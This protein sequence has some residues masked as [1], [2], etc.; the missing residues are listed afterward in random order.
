[1]KKLR[2]AL[3]VL[4][5]IALVGIAGL[6]AVSTRFPIRYMDIITANAGELEPSLVLAVIMAESS[7]NENALSRVGAQGLMQLMPA[8]AADIARRMGNTAFV[9]DD[10]WDSET[11]ITMGMFYLNWLLQRYNGDIR[12]ALAAYNA[13]LGNVDSWLSNPQ[14]SSDGV[15]LDVIP[16]PETYN[17]VQ[18]IQQFQRIYRVLLM[19]Q[20][21]SGA[22]HSP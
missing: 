21:Y 15:T 22:S 14:F 4:F 20:G 2:N 3:L 10:V 5:V 7:F 18:R 1:M 8:T 6:M 12:I 19:L 16:F 13:G 17:Y 9:P 11:N